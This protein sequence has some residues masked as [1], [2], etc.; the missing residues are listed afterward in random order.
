MPLFNV[1]RSSILLQ[2]GCRQSCSLCSLS[3]V[4]D[5]GAQRV[6][7][8]LRQCRKSWAQQKHSRSVALWTAVQETMHKTQSRAQKCRLW[9]RVSIYIHAESA[10]VVGRADWIGHLWAFEQS[11]SYQHN[12]TLNFLGW[13][14]H[15]NMHALS[16]EPF[17]VLSLHSWTTIV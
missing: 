12:Q 1:S 4:L 15:N 2:W 5:T 3:L 10:C 17:S 11:W 8:L 14:H 16:Y 9:I 7:L 6:Q 13:Q